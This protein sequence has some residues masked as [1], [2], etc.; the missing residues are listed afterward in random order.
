M[1]EQLKLSNQLCHRLYKATNAITRAYKP[2]LDKLDLTYP[3][4]L[5]MMALWQEDGVEIGK[6]KQAC[7]IDAGALTL[8]LKKLVSK[9]YIVQ[10]PSEHDKRVKIITLTQAGVALAEA[11]KPI[12]DA[13]KCQFSDVDKGEV[14]ALA[15]L[16]DKLNLS[17]DNSTGA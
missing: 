7:Q 9:D 16:L 2:H 15:N 4:Y 17:L 13:M 10:T 1:N 3:Q 6:I 8:I 11:A 12:P 14:E 5:V